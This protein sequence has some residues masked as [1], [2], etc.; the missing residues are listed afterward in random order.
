MDSNTKPTYS[1]SAT[2]INAVKYHKRK[3]SE[4]SGLA[5]I[6]K[7]TKSY[8]DNKFTVKGYT[9][10]DEVF[11]G[12][13]SELNPYL[14]NTDKQ[15]WLNKILDFGS[16]NIRLSGRCDA[17][18]KDRKHIYDIKRT[19]YH[20]KNKYSRENTIQH[21]LYMFLNDKAEDFTY[22]IAT[23]GQFDGSLIY[24]TETYKRDKDLNNIIL[25]EIIDFL[26]YL[27]ETNLLSHYIKNFEFVS[28]ESK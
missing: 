18:S 9:F 17:I 21:D 3:N 26:E 5:L 6:Q 25:T 20:Y 1:L 27:Q 16:F 4:E 19:Q 23:N 11:A 28:Y 7:L 10:E 15:V 8:E 12:T 14:E 2:L 13:H 22:L 24:V